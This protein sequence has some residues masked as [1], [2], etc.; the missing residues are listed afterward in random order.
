MFSKKNKN[1]VHEKHIIIIILI[2]YILSDN[3]Y[4]STIVDITIS[5]LFYRSRHPIDDFHLKVKFININLLMKYPGLFVFYFH[6]IDE[7]MLIE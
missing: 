3:I 1:S 2:K 7:K 5:L 4:C 6:L